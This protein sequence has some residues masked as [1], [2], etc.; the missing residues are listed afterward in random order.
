MSKR[1]EFRESRRDFDHFDRFD[2][3]PQPR[4]GGPRSGGGM[5]Q[6]G[7]GFAPRAPFDGGRSAPLDGPTSRGT[8]KWF[9][10]E[11][12]FGF[13]A[14]DGGEDA[15]LHASVLQRM[16][17]DTVSPGATMNV[18]TRPGLKGT[19]I[20]EVVDIDDSTATAEAPRAPRSFDRPR[21]PRGGGFA[22]RAASSTGNVG[23]VKWYN[24]QKGFGFIT[25][26]NLD[27]DVFVHASAVQRA[28]LAELA[29]GQPVV[30][31]VAEGKKGPEAVAI[32][33]G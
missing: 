4:F 16:G 2:E 9:N 28:G 32:R 17:R 21:E 31:D 26:E 15:F 30:V 11:K 23:T 3:A 24:A 8:V 10:A 1:R 18:R 12:G 20:A 13:V 19:Q 7:G 27:R 33:L 6:G 14:L 29:E 5:R 22:P 25:V